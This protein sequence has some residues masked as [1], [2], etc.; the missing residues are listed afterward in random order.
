[1]LATQKYAEQLGEKMKLPEKLV[2]EL[3]THLKVVSR[4]HQVSMRD[5][6]RILSSVALFPDEVLQNFMRWSWGQQ[7]VVYTLVF[8]KVVSPETHQKFL[9]SS[10]TSEEIIEY[11]GAVSDLIEEKIGE[12]YN[13]NYDHPTF[14]LNHSWSYIIGKNPD[15]DYFRRRDIFGSFHELN[16]IPRLLHDRVMNIFSI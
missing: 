10:I 2:P 3:C 1:M 5:V 11:F 13:D 6:Q 12:N 14:L 15:S 16:K 8:S 4:V 9:D 7:I